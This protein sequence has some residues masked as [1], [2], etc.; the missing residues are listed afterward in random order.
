MRDGR[1]RAG[2]CE[3]EGETWRPSRATGSRSRWNGSIITW[4]PRGSTSSC[5]IRRTGRSKWYDARRPHGG[6]H[7][8]GA[9]LQ[10][11]RPAPG[12]RRWRARIVCALA[13]RSGGP[14][15]A[16]AYRPRRRSACVLTRPAR[17]A[18]PGPSASATAAVRYQKSADVPEAVLLPRRAAGAPLPQRQGDGLLQA[19]GG[20]RVRGRVHEEAPVEPAGEVRSADPLDPGADRLGTRARTAPRS[21]RR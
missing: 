6:G 8:C 4:V 21:P 16:R 17:A 14:A 7:G 20:R 13:W 3:G 5:T 10:T 1:V 11:A 2:P 12:R 18:R 15:R 9:D 19:A